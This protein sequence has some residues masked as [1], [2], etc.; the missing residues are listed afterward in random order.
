MANKNITLGIIGL[1]ATVTG[2]LGKVFYRDYININGIN[3][4]GFAGFLPSYFYVLGFSLL[5]LVRPNKHPKLIIIIVTVASI[6]FELK[7]WNS[8][9][10]LD[11]KDILASIIGGITSFLILKRIEKIIK[12]KNHNT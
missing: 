5:L 10:N 2:F 8:T 4:Y 7:Q 12:S 6:L 11:V 9:G 3:D 1:L